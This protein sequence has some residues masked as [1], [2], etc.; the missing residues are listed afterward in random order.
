[1]RCVRADPDMMPIRSECAEILLAAGAD[2]HARD[3]RGLTPVDLAHQTHAS[4]LVAVFE[5][6]QHG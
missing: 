3:G 1:M 5:R 2:M 6:A 4:D